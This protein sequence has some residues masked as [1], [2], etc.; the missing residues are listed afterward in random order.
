MAKR[1][2]FLAALG[3]VLLLTACA[4]PVP[5]SPIAVHPQPVHPLP[6]GSHPATPTPTPTTPG[7]STTPAPPSTTLVAG[8]CTSANTVNHQVFV[9]T[10]F[11]NDA[12]TPVTIHYT[13][14]DRDNTEPVE[15]LTTVGPIVYI[16]GYDCVAE[17]KAPT[18]TL[19]AS[20]TTNDGL[21][22]VMA[23]SG[24]IVTNDSLFSPTA[25]ASPLS[26][27]CSGNPGE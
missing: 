2:L 21:G 20:T 13:A 19:T 8:D 4:A 22:C 25:T 9:Y 18:F 16:I 5:T 6:L 26:V 10:V 12:T 14:F 15:T 17:T 7:G 3:T 23:F 11:T 1:F 27:D 24:I